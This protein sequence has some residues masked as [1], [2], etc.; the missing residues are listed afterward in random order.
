MGISRALPL[1]ARDA[2]LFKG[3]QML[4]AY[5]VLAELQAAQEAARQERAMFDAW[6][7]HLS[8][9]DFEK[10]RAEYLRKKDEAR[11]EATEERRHRELCEAIRSTSFWR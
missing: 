10:M 11:K 1:L 6:R 4:G 2:V 3:K 9:D 8:T 5:F 7:S